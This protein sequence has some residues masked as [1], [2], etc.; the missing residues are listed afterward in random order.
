MISCNDPYTSKIDPGSYGSS[1]PINSSASGPTA[2]LQKKA[3]SATEERSPAS[4]GCGTERRVVSSRGWP[5]GHSNRTGSVCGP[6][7]SMYAICANIDPQHHPNV[8]IIYGSPMEC[9]GDG[10]L[11]WMNMDSVQLTSSPT[12]QR[13]PVDRGPGGSAVGPSVREPTPRGFRQR[14]RHGTSR[15]LPLWI[16]RKKTTAS[17]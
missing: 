2:L 17:C 6:K 3:W 4:A 5:Q 14:N 7:H 1:K 13:G 15:R 8:G 11:L 12:K 16:P 10:L 9:L